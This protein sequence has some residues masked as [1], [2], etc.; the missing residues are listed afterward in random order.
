MRKINIILCVVAVMSVVMLQAKEPR[1]KY[2]V[3]V[4]AASASFTDSL[5]YV[6]DVQFVDSAAVSNRMLMERAQYSTQ[7]KTYLENNGMGEN[8]TCFVLYGRKPKGVMKEVKKLKEKYRKNTKVV[9][10]DVTKDQFTF[11]NP[12]I[13]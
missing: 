1:K 13:Y 9:V 10:K 5:V 2:G 6:S 11:S 4:A 3:Y 8:R 7:F 12:E